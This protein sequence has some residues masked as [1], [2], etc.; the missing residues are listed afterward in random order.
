[1]QL[2]V[3]WRFQITSLAAAVSSVQD[4]WVIIC[5]SDEV[6]TFNLLPESSGVMYSLIEIEPKIKSLSIVWTI[7]LFWGVP[8]A[9][10]ENVTSSKKNEELWLT[11]Q[12]L[13]LL[14]S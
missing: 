5:R 1:M 6:S 3:D 12:Q 9:V 13:G 11:I 14:M 4:A 7:V 2:T 10:R 8:E